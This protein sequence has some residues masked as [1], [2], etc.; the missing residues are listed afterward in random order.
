MNG[1][2]EA[3]GMAAALLRAGQY[4]HPHGP[5]A[6]APRLFSIALSREA[7]TGGAL[8]G[9]ELG[10][11]L[12]WP[13]YD[14]EILDHLASELH[15]EVDRL[16]SI[17]ERPGNWLVESLNAFAAHSTISEVTYYRRLLKL[18]LALGA[19]GHCV[20]VGRG[21]MIA[22]P[23]ESTLRVRLVASL[24]DRIAFIVKE[25][26]LKPAEAAGF[27][28]STDRER[29]RFIKDHFRKDV[30]DPLIYDLVLNTSRLSIEECAD[31]VV[32]ALLRLQARHPGAKPQHALAGVAAVS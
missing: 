7:G 5:D 15:V 12:N 32:E 4:S 14:H 9:R 28:E 11:R 13:V 29:R 2:G 19:K 10:R 22:L 20:I 3:F 16:E 1:K 30:T 24:H 26:G 25:L 17:D 31:L 18:L 8:V 6:P 23:V 27:V 21:A